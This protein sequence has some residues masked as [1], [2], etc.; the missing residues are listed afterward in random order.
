MKKKRLWA[1]SRKKKMPKRRLKGKVV[2]DK[3]TKAATVLIERKYRHPLY[4]KILT[5]RKKLHVRNE[6]GAIVGQTVKVVEIKPVSKT[7]SHKIVEIEIGI[8]EIVTK[9]KK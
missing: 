8:S 7:I 5:K 4:G 3:M 1:S 2:S 6:I 9:P